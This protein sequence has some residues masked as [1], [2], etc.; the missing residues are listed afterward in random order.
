MHILSLALRMQGPRV[1]IFKEGPQGMRDPPLKKA[2][3][4]PVDQW[5]SPV[6]WLTGLWVCGVEG[7]ERREF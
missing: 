5:H 7:K 6:P 3:E 4:S 2:Q 1:C